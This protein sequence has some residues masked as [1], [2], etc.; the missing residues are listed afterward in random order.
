MTNIPPKADKTLEIARRTRKNLN[1][2]Y[3]AKNQG[4]DVEEFT[5]LLNSMLGM[6]ISL[7]EDYFA[8]SHITWQ[9]VKSMDLESWQRNLEISGKVSSDLSPNLQKI[10]SFSQ[11]DYKAEKCI[12]A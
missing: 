10:N 6:L 1:F 5:Q 4:Q 2:I 7:K 8:G 12:C 3:A 11:I 9:K